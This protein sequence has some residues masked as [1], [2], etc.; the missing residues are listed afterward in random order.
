MKYKTDILKSIY[1]DFKKPEEE[2]LLTEIYP[3]TS[4]IKHTIKNLHKWMH[5]K[6]VATP[7]CH[8]GAKCKIKYEPRGISLIMSPWN[9]PFQLTIDPLISAIAAG[10]CVILKP[11]EFSPSTTACMKKILSE[12]FEQ[13][14]IAVFEGDYLVSQLLLQKPFDN[15]FSQEA[16]QLG[17]LLSVPLQKIS[18]PLLLNLEENPR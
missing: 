13:N 3:V 11:S 16:L 15:I 6:K 2:V 17:K 12:V 18:L 5:D 1:M 7:L 9:F 14:E 10:N 8:F 4:E